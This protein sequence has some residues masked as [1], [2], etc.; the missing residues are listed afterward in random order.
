MENS[1]HPASDVRPDGRSV[2]SVQDANV[3][4]LF[5]ERTGSGGLW[6]AFFGALIG[7]GLAAGGFVIGVGATGVA[8]QTT[9]FWYLSRSAGMV[10]YLLLWGSVVWGLLLSTKIG[11]GVLRAPI[12]LDA[13]QFVSNA[14]LG[15]AVFHGLILMGDRYLSFPLHAVL[16]PFASQYEPLLVAAGQMGLWLSLTLSVSFLVRQKLGA[17]RW[18]TLHYVSFLAFWAVFVHALLLGTDSKLPW[19]QMLYLFSAGAVVFLTA[20]RVLTTRRKPRSAA[21]VVTSA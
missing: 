6:G 20:Y 7:V 18:R 10:A 12:L 19:S 21:A 3:Q 5:Q 11:Q 2:T 9:S 14:A 1:N 4:L 17:R 13:H 8:G 15:F 16:V